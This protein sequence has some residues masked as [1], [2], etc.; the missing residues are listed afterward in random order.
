MQKQIIHFPFTGEFYVRFTY[1]TGYLKII[2]AH[3]AA[4]LI[5]KYEIEIVDTSFHCEFY[6]VTLKP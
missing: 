3:Q 2:S 6:Y 1:L 4:L 5:R